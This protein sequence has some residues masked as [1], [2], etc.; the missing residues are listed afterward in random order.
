MTASA[1][2]FQDTLNYDLW[3]TSKCLE[4][5]VAL[6]GAKG[7]TAR[8]AIGHVLAAQRIW[9]ARLQGTSHDNAFFP[10]LSAEELSDYYA[11]NLAALT[12]YKDALTDAEVDREVV[13]ENMKGIQYKRTVRKILTHFVLHGQY[14]RGQIALRLRMEGGAPIPTDYTYWTDEG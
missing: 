5:V 7:A 3:A 1:S 2:Y 11:R 10:E 4:G 8:A 12:A 6:P 14:H 13:F 9:L